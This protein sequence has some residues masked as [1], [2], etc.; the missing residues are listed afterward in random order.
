MGGTAFSFYLAVQ[1]LLPN[2]DLVHDRVHISTYL[3][4]AVDLVRRKECRQLDKAGDK[5][6]TGSKEVWLRNLENMDEQQQTELTRL[7]DAEFR[8]GKAWALKHMFRSFWQLGC[9][10]AGRFLFEYWSKR[11]DEVSLVPFTTFKELLRRHFGNLLTCF[12]PSITNAV[13][14]GLNSK[15]QIV[16]ALARGFERF[17]SDR[18][19]ILF[20]FGKLNMA[21]GA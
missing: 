9:A 17:E 12:K 21:I 5:R 11:L 8:T 2:A 7:M 15:I 16:K 10:D 19:Q 4:E 1:E 3:N 14:E 18:I 6:L 13:P 20:Y